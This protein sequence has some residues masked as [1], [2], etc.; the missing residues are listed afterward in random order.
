M[1]FKKYPIEVAIWGGDNGNYQLTIQKSYK[2]KQSGEYKSSNF[3]FDNE[4]LIIPYLL[5]RANAWIDTQKAN[6]RGQQQGQQQQQQRQP[7]PQQ[8]VQQ[9]AKDP[10]EQQGNN[11]GNNGVS[12]Q[13]VPF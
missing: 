13:D 6:N 4:S 11:Q 1:S 7:A 5:N 12:E 10:W 3:F 8:Q 9:P 2:D